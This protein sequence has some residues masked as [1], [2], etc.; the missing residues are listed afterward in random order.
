M[1]DYI[2][3]PVDEKGR[4]LIPPIFK[5]EE[6]EARKELM[7]KVKI[8]LRKEG[9]KVFRISRSYL[10]FIAI[11]VNETLFIKIIPNGK[12][13]DE[14]LRLFSERYNAEVLIYTNNGKKRITLERKKYLTMKC[15]CGGKTKFYFSRPLTCSSCG[16]PFKHHC[17]W[18]GKEFTINSDTEWCNRCAWYKCPDGH[19]GCLLK[20]ALAILSLRKRGL[21]LSRFKRKRRRKSNYK[22]TPIGIIKNG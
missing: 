6:R 12:V 8:E 5:N 10:D 20:P 7:K 4:P 1:D 11:K 2:P 19:C 17:L 3:I 13:D 14:K 16:R 21:E 18:C 9:Y 22:I 15:E